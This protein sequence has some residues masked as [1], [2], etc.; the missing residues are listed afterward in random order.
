MKLRAKLII[1]F[2]LLSVVPLTGIVL[3]SY[4]TSR[5]AMEAS[6]EAEADALTRDMERRMGGVRRDLEMGVRRVGPRLVRNLVRA[7]ESGT[8]MSPEDLERLVGDLGANADLIDTFTIVPHPPAAPRP[9][10]PGEAVAAPESP[11][12]AP[13]NAGWIV[14]VAEVIAQA[15]KQADT[16]APPAATMGMEVG[17]TIFREVMAGGL[18]EIIEEIEVSG[19]D[20]PAEVED[21]SQKRLV[22]RRLAREKRFES[23]VR[24]IGEGIA[25]QTLAEDAMPNVSAPDRELSL[26]GM[27]LDT[28]VR[29]GDV[30]LGQVKP[31]IRRQA[32]VHHVLARTDR[33]RGEVPFALDAAGTL[34]VAEEADRARLSGLALGFTTETP[35]EVA[36]SEV[37]DTEPELA[38]T[39]VGRSGGESYSRRL[40]DWLVVQSNDPGSGLSFGIARPLGDS[41]DGVRQA[42]LENFL[43]G[44]GLIA[45]ALLGIL[46]LSRRMTRNLELVT[47]GAERVAAGDLE[48][49]VP[50]QSSDEIGQLAGTFNRMAHDLRSNQERLV[51]QGL[52]QRLLEV[53]LTRKNDELE[54][55]RRFQLAMLPSTLPEH[56]SFEVAVA[57]LTATEVGG[58]YYDFRVEGETLVVAVGDATGHGST[59]GRMVTVVKTL[60]VAHETLDDPA[61]FLAGANTS[62]RRMGLGRM[63][64]ALGLARFTEDR[65]TLAAAGMPPALIYRKAKSDVEELIT[66]G[67]PLGGLDFDY[68]GKTATLEPGDVVLLSS[69]GYPELPDQAGEPLGYEVVCAHFGKVAG[70][71]TAQEI[72][73]AL[74][75]DVTRRTGGAAPADDVTFVVVKVR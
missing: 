14:D 23:L 38:N 43:A 20:S 13:P 58:D 27:E 52:D 6:L 29:D 3:F 16:D 34:F 32:V 2:V 8:T 11:P 72:V 65:L 31:K 45:V 50:I 60:L 35:P 26:L 69:D 37:A 62:V 4:W 51:A 61:S 46:P 9:P 44:L 54:E 33:G 40:G 64:M 1:A 22:A 63:A 5:R 53:E 74:V 19:I 56:P 30:L 24:R 68:V 47:A 12:H 17:F 39:D 42:A 67:M 66:Q 28:T 57:M 18:A 10:K 36:A 41:L 71:S 48:T 21:A 59:A 70:E 55:A 15:R 49:A 73:D 25:G 75:A 7:R